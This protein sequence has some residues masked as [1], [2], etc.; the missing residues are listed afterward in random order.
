MV[1]GYNDRAVQARVVHFRGRGLHTISLKCLLVMGRCSIRLS[2]SV[3]MVCLQVWLSLFLTFSYRR[4]GIPNSMVA[5]PVWA[6]QARVVEVAAVV[7]ARVV[8]VG[9][10]PLIWVGL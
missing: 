10:H 5:S 4:Q 1:R 2:D 6:A 7:Q 3:V 8:V 9:V